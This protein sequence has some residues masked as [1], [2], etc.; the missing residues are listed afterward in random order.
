MRSNMEVKTVGQKI[1]KV[2]GQKTRETEIKNQFHG[3]FFV[4]FPFSESK[5]GR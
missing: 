4:Y 2:P 1:L 5:N 3:F